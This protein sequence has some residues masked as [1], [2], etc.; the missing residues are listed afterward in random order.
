MGVRVGSGAEHII[1]CLGFSVKVNSK[2]HT[3][4]G[5]RSVRLVRLP[6]RVGTMYIRCRGVVWRSVGPPGPAALGWPG[7]VRR[8]V[9][10]AG[11]AALD[12]YGS[13]GIPFKKSW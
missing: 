1:L 13:A 2:L 5:R 7:A 6:S 10:L 3:R 8:S 9:G 4:S 11:P 12:L